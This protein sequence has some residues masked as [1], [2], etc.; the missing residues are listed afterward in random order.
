MLKPILLCMAIFLV[1]SCAKTGEGRKEPAGPGEERTAAP[2]SV[3]PGADGQHRWAAARAVVMCVGA[4]HGLPR[5]RTVEEA[6]AC[7]RGAFVGAV[8]PGAVA[9]SG[10]PQRARQGFREWH[11][12]EAGRVCG[13]T[14]GEFT[15]PP[16][17]AAGLA[18]W[19]AE[20]EMQIAAF[21]KAA[22]DG[23]DPLLVAAD[24]L[25]GLKVPGQDPE[26]M[27]LEASLRAAASLPA[28]QP[29]PEETP[30]TGPGDRDSAG[31]RGMKEVNVAPVA[32]PMPGDDASLRM[33]EM[34]DPG[35]A[36]R[37]RQKRTERAVVVAVMNARRSEVV[38]CYKKA[39]VKDNYL[40]GTLKVTFTVTAPGKAASC[41]VARPLADP[42]VGTCACT[43]L[44][45][46]K[47]AYP[48][49]PDFTHTWSWTLTLGD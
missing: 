40:Q 38:E 3:G 17:D 4:E 13:F 34:T 14:A 20:C 39:R 9:G 5:A 8:H 43:R 11:R 1:S 37:E 31:D 15:A 45:T 41:T 21:V 23:K 49:G 16:P 42:T 26:R 7:L 12:V 35:A 36:A 47:F 28:P 32:P 44:M 25:A 22:G 10:V 19:K 48:E 46:W 33:M 29:A 2:P 24:Y 27:A 18:A 6:H 30:V